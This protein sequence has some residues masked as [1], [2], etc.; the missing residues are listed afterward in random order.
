MTTQSTKRRSFT[1]K[2][3]WRVHPDRRDKRTGALSPVKAC[4][5]YHHLFAPYKRMFREEDKV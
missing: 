2:Y 4:K 1:P 5:Y 3:V